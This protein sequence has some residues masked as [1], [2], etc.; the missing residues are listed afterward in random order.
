VILFYNIFRLVYFGG[1]QLAAGWNA[2]AKLWVDG[3][4]NWQQR[5]QQKAANLHGARV[6][7]MH[8]ASLGEFEQGRPVLEKIKTQNPKIKIA[9]TFFSPSG[10]EIRKDYKGADVVMYL[11]PDSKQNAVVFLNLVQPTLVL[12]IKYEFWHYY[13]AELKHRNIETILISGVF[14]N[15]QPF[16]QWWGGFH[17]NMLLNFSHL[18]VQNQSSASQ[19]AG[20]NIQNNVTVCGD[21]RFDRVL[22]TAHNWQ[23]VKY[24]DDFCKDQFVIVAGST[25]EQDELL[26]CTYLYDHFN[27]HRLI[28]APHEINNEHIN[29]IRKRFP[30]S[31]CYSEIKDATQLTTEIRCLIIDSIGMLSQLY[32]YGT[33]TYVGGGFSK[34]GIHNVLEAAVYGIP[35]FTGPNIQKFNEAIE[36]KQAGALFTVNDPHSFKEILHKIKIEETGRVAKE[37]VQQK[38]GATGAIMQYLQEKRLFTSA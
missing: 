34:S 3:R 19:L 35:V 31:I 17:K 15:T 26:L 21:T 37:Y 24:I 38:T 20:I 23:P 12:F 8:C 11:P 1:I 32:K 2:K 33:I 30:D 22:E 18:F 9:L 36:L 5:L 29:A 16:F 13:L 27:H 4:K 10:Y 6:V 28:L 7:W 14:R 25:W